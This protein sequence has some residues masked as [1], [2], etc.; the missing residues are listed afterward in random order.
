MTL[1]VLGPKGA[2]ALEG[3]GLSLETAVRFGIYTGRSV[4]GGGFE[5]DEAGS[6]VAF[7]FVDRG[8]VVAEKYRA[9]G[10]RFWQRAGGTRTFWNADTLDD[11]GLATGALPL[12]ITEG[13]IDALTA[14]DWGFPTTVS[15]PDGAPSVKPGEDPEALPPDDPEREA[16]GKFE[17]LW[18]NRDRLKRVKRIILA[19]DNDP[20]GRR[21]AAELVRRLG[22]ARCSFVTYPAGCK[23][24]ND[25]LREHGG[26]AVAAVLNGA[27]H[28]PLKGAYKLSDYPP[29][30]DLVTYKTGWRTLDGHMQLFAGEFIVVTGIPNH[31]KSTFVTHLLVNLAESYGWRAAIFSPE[32]PIVPQY[33]DKIRRIH[34]RRP[35]VGDHDAARADAFIEWHFRFI[36]GSVEDLNEETTLPWVVDRA[37]EI[38]QRDGLDVLVIDPWNEVEHSRG[39]HE[40]APDYIGRAIRMLKRFAKQRQVV[41]IVVAHPTK[42]VGEDG[43]GRMP[44]PYD[45]EGSAHWYN[46]PDHIV[47]VHRPD[48]AINET[49]IRI[50]KV[51]FE[52]TGAKGH[53]SM[54]FNRESSRYE[55]LDWRPSQ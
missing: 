48:E 2:T 36:D 5:P 49:V 54:A 34:L 15:V 39:P 20:P 38:H 29:V 16:T 45:I 43:K 25:V 50:A 22:P 40:S 19:V 33:R 23:D 14:I 41:V 18:N 6:V 8:A 27:K 21:L 52:E 7:P 17:F 51:R 4:E 31:G 9:P 13:E 44:M 30:P 53:V 24:L 32:M 10:K 12:V 26:D 28:Y 3:R 1:H 47:I 55:L 42:A 46:K 35:P 11:P 37:E